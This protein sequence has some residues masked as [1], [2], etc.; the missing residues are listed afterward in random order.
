MDLRQFID[1]LKR[2]GHLRRISDPVD[3][4]YELGAFARAHREPLLFEN[5]RDY[6]GCTIFTNGLCSGANIA[7]ALSLDPSISRTGLVRE[8]RRRLTK[9]QS[10][11]VV[12]RGPVQENTMQDLTGLPV[13]LWHHADGGRYLGTWHVNVTR[14]PETRACNCGIYRMQML[15]R[16]T[17]TI[18]V[19]PKSHLALHYAKAEKQG[20]SLEMAVCIGVGESLIMAAA[21]AFP[22]DSCE[23]DYAGAIEGE[24]LE[25]VACKTVDLHVP[26]GAEIVI[27]GVVRPGMRVTDGPFFDYAGVPNVNPR[28]LQFEVT[29]IMHRT[30]PV[31]RGCA[32]GVAGA[33]DHQVFSVL[34]PLGLVDFHGSRTRQS[35]QNFLLKNKMFRSLQLF[36][37]WGHLLHRAKST[38]H[39]AKEKAGM[40]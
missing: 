24:P 18:S 33:E 16:R 7:R 8:L 27:E 15:G 38:A 21:A 13:P 26:A 30:N 6:P 31:F 23:Y 4:Q 28:A 36:T 10:P 2:S 9:P 17:S 5:I 29:A 34:A 3:W 40:Q 25:L 37:R 20:K 12:S 1:A 32:V 22:V 39:T 11:I 35:V 14:D 19:S